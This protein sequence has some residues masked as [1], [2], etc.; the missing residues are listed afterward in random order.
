MKNILLLSISAILVTKAMEQ[1]SSSVKG[2][3]NEESLLRQTLGP[4]VVR[5]QKV[6][7]KAQKIQDECIKVLRTAR[8][9]N[10]LH[11]INKLE[12]EDD[13]LNAREEVYLQIAKAQALEKAA[14]EQF[15]EQT[16]ISSN[17][18]GEKY[19]PLPDV[20]D[21]LAEYIAQLKTSEKKAFAKRLSKT[22]ARGVAIK[23][24]QSTPVE[25]LQDKDQQLPPTR[26]KKKL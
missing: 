5:Y 11:S 17:C 10:Y 15:C 19:L 6:V 7:L 9:T 2:S 24:I 13:I 12:E 4:I 22:M 14:I 16:V 3:V 20:D 8:L 25:I 26:K 1:P 18:L 21:T 23:E